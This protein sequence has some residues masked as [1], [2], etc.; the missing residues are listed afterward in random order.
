M[1]V[2]A[3]RIDLQGSGDELGR[4]LGRTGLHVS[5]A[6]QVTGVEMRRMAL[7]DLLIDRLCLCG[8]STLVEPQGLA[9][10]RIDLR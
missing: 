6:K 10:Q 2:G 7:E 1:C 8:H 5:H 9:E 3:L 4:A